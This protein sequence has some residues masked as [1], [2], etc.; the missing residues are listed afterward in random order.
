MKI[1]LVNKFFYLKGG[2]EFVF[3][4]TAKLLKNKGHQIMFFSMDHPRNLKSEYGKYFVSNIDY[5]RK[6]I[7]NIIFSSLRL[8]YS[9]QAKRRIEELISIEKPDIAHLHNIYHQISPS[10]LHALKKYNIPIVM[11]IHDFKL[12]CASY[13][14]FTGGH[15]CEACRGGRYYQCFL[16][17]CVKDSPVKSLLNTME[18]YWHHKMLHIYD[19]VDIFISPSRFHKD[20]I[21]E[22][23]FKGKII[24]LSNFINLKEYTP[25]YSSQEKS[26]VYLGRLSRE[27][28]LGVLLEAM[29]GIGAKLK[30]IG[31]GPLKKILFEKTRLENQ[32]NVEFLGYKTL[33]ELKKEIE[34][35][36]FLILP[37][38]CYENNPLSI[39]QA[40]A[41]GKP[42]IASRN[43]G[44]PELV[45]DNETGLTFLPGD[46][47]D[48]RA[49]I[50]QLLKDRAGQERMG[51]EARR[52]IEENCSSEVHYKKLL[53]IY[54]S[55]LLKQGVLE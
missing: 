18:M 50:L 3:F 8:L 10:I 36:M 32:K 14:L 55:V 21:R 49:K 52:M 48:L 4:E 44:V 17:K 37:S 46:V 33:E 40:F 51:R 19:L 39:M 45:R 35:A 22:M 2:A 24:Y 31:D 11:T 47:G 30:I 54:N 5:G 15:I 34:K 41:L 38:E 27:K 53:G 9:M 7:K 20:K 16:K 42:V 28:G 12:V 6:G 26:V 29:K 1:L 25:S 13:L 43:G 23:G